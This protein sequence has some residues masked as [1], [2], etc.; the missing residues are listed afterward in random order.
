MG[1][2]DEGNVYNKTKPSKDLR[3]F[4]GLIDEALAFKI[5]LNMLLKS[6]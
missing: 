5:P 1:G 3:F 2:G 6:R 4:E